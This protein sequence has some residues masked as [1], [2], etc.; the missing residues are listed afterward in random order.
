MIQRDFIMRMIQEAAEAIAALM[1]YRQGGKYEAA[2]KLMG[3]TYEA[4]FPFSGEQLRQTE[5]ADI[6]AMILEEYS[7]DEQLLGTL[8]DLL[9]E[10]GEYWFEQGQYDKAKAALRRS[11]IL[12]K[13]MNEQES[14]VYSIDRM[15]KL[16]L[17][18]DRLEDL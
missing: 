13:Y 10:E 15:N 1:G 17:I 7:V 18:E 8:A 4:Y 14:E 2:L 9:R 6:V 3:E 5:E 11:M 16:G 12:I